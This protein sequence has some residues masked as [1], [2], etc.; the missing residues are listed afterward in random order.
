MRSAATA[1]DALQ[2]AASASQNNVANASTPGY[3]KQRVLIT[4]MPYDPG[5]QLSGG[6]EVTRMVTTRDEFAEQAVRDQTSAL[7]SAGEKAAQMS[8]LEGNFALDDA[9]GIAARMDD[10]F[11]TF[12]SWAIAPLSVSEKT[13]VISA[14]QNVA[15]AF[16]TTAESLQESARS[17]EVRI[18]STFDRI[19]DIAERIR[20]HNVEV[21]VNG[22]TEAGSEATVHSDLEELAQYVD[23][24]TLWQND[25]TVTV[26]I[27]RQTALVTGDQKF[28]FRVSPDPAAPLAGLS[29]ATPK[30][31]IID[32]TGA[33]V[34]A[35]MKSGQLGALFEF[36]NSTIPDLAGSV[37]QAGD[38]N[39][40]ASGFADRINQI[41]TGGDPNAVK[42]FTYSSLG[43]AAQSMQVPAG[44]TTSILSAADPSALPASANGKALQL[45][46]LAHPGSAQDEIDGLS[47][48]SF[49][50]NVSAGVGRLSREADQ[51]QI[52]HQQ[53]HA[54][55]LS[56]RE[57]ISG[58][59][60]D[61]EAVSLV[62][63]QRTYEA[64]SRMIA[65]IDEMTKIA[66]NLGRN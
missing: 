13:S 24:Q 3:A 22:K 21:R 14:A 49:F 17:S 4:A 30:L 6:V 31:Q 44:M 40:L 11:T 53:L 46:A 39:R 47:Y 5:Q 34:T 43:S 2:K 33:D 58:I 61:E 10:L 64:T 16:R 23:F 15:E 28:Q 38:L 12:N 25:G 18:Q 8:F 50:G 32:H 51:A 63:I 57:E 1:L 56:V 65:A 19:D 48:V 52:S 9:T 60:L 42:L 29:G 55:A 7:G 62:A 66:V 27:G 35:T 26:L 37:T 59:S 36:R 54:Q 20:S 45:A 41:V